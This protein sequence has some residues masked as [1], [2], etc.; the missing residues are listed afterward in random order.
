MLFEKVEYLKGEELK[1]DEYEKYNVF[2]AGNIEENIFNN[3]IIFIK[4]STIGWL[5]IG[6]P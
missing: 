4:K 2:Y 6:V 3:T 1:E 5:I